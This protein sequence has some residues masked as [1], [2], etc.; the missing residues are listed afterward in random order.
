MSNN[1]ENGRNAEDIYDIL[2]TDA[3]DTFDSENKTKEG[4]SENPY[5]PAYDPD[6]PSGSMFDNYSDYTDN[7]PGYWNF[8]RILWIVGLVTAV[9]LIVWI[10]TSGVPSYKTTD[11][12]SIEKFSKHGDEIENNETVFETG[13]ESPMPETDEGTDD[14]EF[15]PLTQYKLVEV[16]NNGVS[17]RGNIALQ[18]K[19]LG[20]TVKTFERPGYMD[21]MESF[22]ILSATRQRK[23]GT[24]KI[25]M[26]SGEDIICTIDFADQRELDSFVNSMR[27]SHYL[28]SGSLY[29]H[30]KNALAQIYA[31]VNGLKVKIICP[32]EMLPSNF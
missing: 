15:T 10:A 21:D 22:K 7:D 3:S 14:E 8:F 27:D 16:H 24:T 5:D 25:T 4:I 32:F 29:W 30:P 28:N 31:R 17:F 1:N 2:G 18:L 9:A 19:S 26:E 13:E 6:A 11:Y 12:S 23:T 20:F